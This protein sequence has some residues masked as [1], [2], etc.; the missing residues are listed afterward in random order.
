MWKQTFKGFK[1]SYAHRVLSLKETESEKCANLHGHT[2]WVKVKV[3]SDFNVETSTTVLFTTVKKVV[4]QIVKTFDHKTFLYTKDAALL[5]ALDLLYP[6]HEDFMSNVVLFC[7]ETTAEE[8]SSLIF[9]RISTELQKI[10]CTLIS[11][12]I[13]ETDVWV[14]YKPIKK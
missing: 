4:K 9:S 1:F 13:K 3:S 2:A 14:T 11:V 7:S 5:G 12:S 10:N 6:K 8:I